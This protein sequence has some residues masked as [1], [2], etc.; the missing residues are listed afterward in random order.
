MKLALATAYLACNMAVFGQTPSTPRAHNAQIYQLG[1]TP[2]LGVSALDIHADRAKALKLKEETG[3]EVTSVEPDS[4]AAK[5]GIKVGDVILQ[6]NGE[7]VEGWEHLKRLVKETPV[8]RE[9]KILLWRNGAEQ[10]VSATIGARKGTELDLGGGNMLT[11]PA[12]PS[13]PTPPMPPSALMPPASTLPQFEMPEFRTF[14]LT[15]S[16]GII[17]EPLGQE[18]QLAEYFGVKEG[19]LVRSVNKESAAEKGGI[20]A[21]DVIT[22]IDDTAISTPQ[23]ISGALRAVH[24]KNSV[25]VTV[26]R[27]RKETTLTVTPDAYGYFRGGIWDPGDNVLLQLFGPGQQRKD[28]Q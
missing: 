20:K 9:V 5:A 7:K 27:N 23:Q 25:T 12:W 1:E 13:T 22:K 21:G 4:A 2:Y 26:V 24:G 18:S 8:H 3:V 6:Y 10:T 19:V 11:V 28:R 16:L 15:S 14:M 17:G